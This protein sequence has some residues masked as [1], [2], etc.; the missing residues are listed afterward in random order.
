MIKYSFVVPIYN[1]AYLAEEFCQEYSKVFQQ[2][3]GM[4]DITPHVELI[5]VNDGSIDNSALSTPS[6]CG[7]LRRFR[8]PPRVA[9]GGP[10]PDLQG[11]GL[12]GGRRGATGRTEEGP[13]EAGR[14]SQ[15]SGS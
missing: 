8:D 3:L 15:S 14:L 11:R 6:S 9:A 2:H 13:E 1:D 5:F 7:L 12:E 4:A 10:E